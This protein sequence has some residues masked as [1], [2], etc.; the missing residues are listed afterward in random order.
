MRVPFLQG[1]SLYAASCGSCWSHVSS[2]VACCVFHL[3]G[4]SVI[5]CQ[6]PFKRVSIGQDPCMKEAGG[7]FQKETALYRGCGWLQNLCAIC[8]AWK[9]CGRLQ[10]MKLLCIYQNKRKNNLIQEHS[11]SSTCLPECKWT[12]CHCC[13]A[14]CFLHRRTFVKEGAADVLAC[15]SL[16]L[17]QSS[18]FCQLSNIVCEGND[19]WK[20]MFLQSWNFL[21]FLLGT[22]HCIQALDSSSITEIDGLKPGS[23][24]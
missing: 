20:C 9:L 16:S 12:C 11:F 13:W 23:E 8:T 3:L 17:G 4:S 18:A 19:F 21:E 24:K 7:H 22:H 14:C 6:G 5:C 15:F 10:W 1:R 2:I